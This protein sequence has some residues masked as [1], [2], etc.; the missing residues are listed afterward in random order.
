MVHVCTFVFT[1][2]D[3]MSVDYREA[4][5]NTIFRKRFEFMTRLLEMWSVLH[6][7]TRQTLFN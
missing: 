5:L 1:A 2:G 6:L 4:A 3:Y 7:S